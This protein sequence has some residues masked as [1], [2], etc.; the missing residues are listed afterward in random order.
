MDQ[1]LVVQLLKDSITLILL[2]SAPVLVTSLTVGMIIAVGQTVTQ[3][4]EAT[5]TFVPK[6]VASLGV[7]V[8]TAPWILDQL[9]QHT[10]GLFNLMIHIATHRSAG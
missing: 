8:I 7:L 2:V 6:V 10:T 3:V 9:I 4:Q 1:T 5:L